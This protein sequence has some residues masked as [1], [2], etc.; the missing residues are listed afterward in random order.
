MMMPWGGM[1]GGG[2]GGFGLAWIIN[3]IVTVAII[4]GLVLLVVWFV[5]QSGGGARLGR[6]EKT[7]LG[8]LKERYARG[9]IEREEFEQ[10]KKDLGV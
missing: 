7:P 5:R 3:L 10:K 8:I 6:E 9:E 1:T 4:V 2:F